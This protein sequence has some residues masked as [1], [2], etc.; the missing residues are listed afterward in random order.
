MKFFISTSATV[1]FALVALCCIFEAFF[2]G[3][4]WLSKKYNYQIDDKPLCRKY[5][6]NI[7]GAWFFT[8]LTVVFVMKISSLISN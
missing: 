7:L 2:Y 4:R 3:Y 5:L 8:T 6:G 1:L